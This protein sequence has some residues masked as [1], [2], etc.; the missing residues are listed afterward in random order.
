MPR[1]VVL[2]VPDD[3]AD[4]IGRLIA[5]VLSLNGYAHNTP[6]VIDWAIVRNAIEAGR[7]GVMRREG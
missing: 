1:A 2:V 3:V 5:S 4:E 7:E 6:A